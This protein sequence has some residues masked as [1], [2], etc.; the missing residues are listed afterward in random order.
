M[1]FLFLLASLPLIKNE[2]ADYME[3]VLLPIAIMLSLYQ[4]GY[5]I[6]DR[7]SNNWR[8][9]RRYG[10]FIAFPVNLACMAFYITYK[11]RSRQHSKELEKSGK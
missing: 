1:P 7:Y 2:S 3:L 9:V 6:T 5:M 11:F 4:L 10:G 8:W